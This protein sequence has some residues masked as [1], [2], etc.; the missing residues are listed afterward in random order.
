MIGEIC[1]LSQVLAAPQGLAAV[2]T[3]VQ[4]QGLKL[5]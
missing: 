2:V 4:G 3:R 5:K 1:K